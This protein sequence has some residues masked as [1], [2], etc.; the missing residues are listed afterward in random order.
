[1]KRI[2]RI[3]A[4]E[5]DPALRDAVQSALTNQGFTVR[6]EADGKNIREAAKTFHPD[7]A[8]L[9]VRLPGGPN[10]LSI[11]QMLR[12]VSTL[13]IIFLTAADTAQ[14]RLAG[15]DAGGDDYIVKPF[16]MAELIARIRVVLRRSG[17]LTDERWQIGD[18]YVD[19]ASRTVERN[20][21]PIELTYTEF[22]LL[23]ALGR[24]P[25]RV[26]SKTQ[27]L[28]SIWG[29][30]SYDHNVVEVRMSGLRK[31]LEEHG[32]RLIETV[33]GLGYKLSA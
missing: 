8:L 29:L 10:G 15:F 30:E 28:A 6:T 5:D 9:D 17:V 20:S 1:M 14:D 19:E 13:P 3:L 27:L 7:L 31:K 16:E 11:A 24:Q 21:V 12:E 33:R 25:N 4:V 2:P 18:L 22:D 26:L 32:P 23:V